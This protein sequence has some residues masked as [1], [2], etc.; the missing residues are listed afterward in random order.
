[1]EFLNS[2]GPASLGLNVQV[3]DLITHVARWLETIEPIS[4]L[5]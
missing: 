1:M 4:S 2:S 3:A 5:T